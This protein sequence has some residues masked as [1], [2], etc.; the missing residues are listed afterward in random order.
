MINSAQETLDIAIYSLTH[1]DIVG[2]EIVGKAYTD[3]GRELSEARDRLA[4]NNQYDGVFEKW[5]ESIG[6]NRMQASR[7]IQILARNKL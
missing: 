2:R 1:P 5:L 6:M 4:G 7:L 3:L